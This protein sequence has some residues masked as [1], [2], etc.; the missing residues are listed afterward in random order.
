MCTA[1]AEM[2]LLC[3]DIN[4]MPKITISHRYVL[5][6]QDLNPPRGRQ[7]LSRICNLHG[8]SQD[9]YPVQVLC[10]PHLLCPWTSFFH[11]AT[12]RLCHWADSLLESFV[13]LVLET[14]KRRLFHA[15]TYLFLL[16][17]VL[18]T[19]HVLSCFEV[20]LS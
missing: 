18:V 5:V 8:L 14:S 1:Y 13:G 4:I 3:L 2:W 20:I 10:R 16:D 12:L 19:Y 9:E 11:V 7:V 15:L 6:V 17:K